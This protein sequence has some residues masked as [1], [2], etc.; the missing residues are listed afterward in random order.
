M[1]NLYKFC[2]IMIVSVSCSPKNWHSNSQ[3]DVYTYIRKVERKPSKTLFSER[4][5][6]AY[7]EQKETKLREIELIKAA[8]KPFDWEIVYE[9][10]KVLNE[11]AQ[12]VDDCHAC[13]V[14]VTPVFYKAEET[15]AL[16]KATLERIDAGMV[17]LS[18]DNKQEAQRA[19]YHFIK[20]KQLSPSRKDID[21][22][23]DESIKKGTTTIVIEGDYKYDSDYV[24][25]IEKSLLRSLP[26]YKESKLFYQFFS[27]QQALAIQ[28]QPDYVI[29]FGF[30]YLDVGMLHSHCSDESFT[31]DIKVGERKID[32]VK[33]E[34]I[35]EKVSAK[36][37]KCRKT[38][39]AEGKI[40]FEIRD[41]QQDVSVLREE[42]YDDDTWTNEWTTVSGDSRAL[43]AGASSAGIESMP[44]SHWTQ[45]NNIT[46]D[47]GSSASWR[48]RRFLKDRNML[49]IK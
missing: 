18:L 8:Q 11:M 42:F 26:K 34:P 38:L 48:I 7:K 39:N 20:A 9:K 36:I 49:A 30:R 24:K 46:S 4:L 25:D 31:K 6:I 10:Y 29:T 14:L 35:Y 3:K 40:W 19:Y 16:Q 41:F 12:K 5:V 32:S 1:K 21:L 43:P 23:I 22:M 37:T 47:L 28:M 15:V 27:P 13:K 17:S 45:F 44:P 2:I 33:V